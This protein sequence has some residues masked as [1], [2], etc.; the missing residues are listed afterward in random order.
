MSGMKI[1][2]LAGA[3]AMLSTGAFAADLAPPYPPPLP[4]VVQAPPAESGFYLRGAIGLTNQSLDKLTQVLDSS[5]ISLE[6]VGMG[7]DS[8]PLFLFGAGYQMNSWFR[9]DVTGEYRAKAN[10]HGTDNV[11]FFDGA[12]TAV[13]ADNYSASKSEILFLA[14]AYLDLGTWYCVTPFIGAGVGMSRNQIDSFRDD[15]VGFFSPQAGGGAINAVAFASS[16][17]TWQFAWALHAGLAYTVTPNFKVDVAYRF[18][19]LGDAVTGP[20]RAFD[21][22]FTNGGAFTF[23]NLE[24]H[25]LMLGVRWMLQPEQPVYSP[26]LIRKG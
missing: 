18:V 9:F 3:A 11:R 8:S 10:F 24:S 4:Q 6:Q 7:F 20:T 26:P 19:H 1:L 14:N 16:N 5:V 22:S 21:G 15:G 13:L 23:K 25:D 12:G 17:A 2:A